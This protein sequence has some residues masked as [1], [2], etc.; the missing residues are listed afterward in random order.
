V[1]LQ[2]SLLLSLSL[3]LVPLVFLSH[4][5]SPPPREFWLSERGGIVEYGSGVGERVVRETFLALIHVNDTVY[6]DIRSSGC[7]VTSYRLKIVHVSSGVS[8]EYEGLGEPALPTFT[9]SMGGVYSMELE[10][11]FEARGDYNLQVE[12]RI[13]RGGKV[14]YAR[15][16][17]YDA[18]VGCVLLLV[19]GLYAAKR[20]KEVL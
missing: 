7:E 9:A 19:V 11:R 20:Y 4:A 17:L 10:V 3:L 12:A 15:L 18:I 8:Y 6:F 5:S 14:G 13:G 2:A 1:R 16:Y